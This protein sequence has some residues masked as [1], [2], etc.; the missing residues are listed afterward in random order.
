MRI[1]RACKLLGE[2]SLNITEIANECG[3]ST[4]RTFNR[5]FLKTV[6]MTPKAYRNSKNRTV[7]ILKN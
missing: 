3:F 6:G 4:I 7:D 1:N 2:D 5:V